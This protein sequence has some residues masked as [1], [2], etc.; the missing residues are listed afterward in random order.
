[1]AMPTSENVVPRKRIRGEV[2][3][4]SRKRDLQRR[5]PIMQMIFAEAGLATKIA[6]RV[7][8]S[9]QS[10][11]MWKRVPAYHVLEVAPMLGLT[12]EQVRPDVFQPKRRGR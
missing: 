3:N 1:M 7:C 2:I 6:K 11:S 8:V 12:P 9:H 4:R 10:V 5:D